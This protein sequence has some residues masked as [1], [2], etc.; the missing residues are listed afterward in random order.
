MTGYKFTRRTLNTGVLLALLP[1]AVWA[2]ART[3]ASSETLNFLVDPEPT[4]LVSITDTGVGTN[5]VTSKTTEGLFNYTNNFTLIPSLALSMTTSNDGKMITFNLRKGVKW[6]DGKPFTSA[7][8]AF[9]FDTL[10]KSH[11]RGRTT[12]ANVT[13]IQIPDESTVVLEMSAPAPYLQYALASEESPM[14][15]KHLYEGTNPATNPR[16]QAPVGTGPFI[17]KEWVRGSH[18]IFEKNPDYW[19]KSQPKV[20]RII[21]H[22][23]PD[24]AARAIA[25]ETGEV[26]IGGETPVP[27]SDVKRLS[28]LSSIGI[29]LNGYAY[30]PI[31]Q[32]I[33]FNLDN[34][35]FKELKVRQAIAHA[36]DKQFIVDNIWFGYG[37]LATGPIH[38]SQTKFY[39]PNVQKYEFDTAKAERLLDEAGFRRQ[40]DGNRFQVNL[41]PLPLTPHPL[42][43]EYLKQALAKIGIAVT[44][45]SQDFAGYMKRVYTDRQF[46][47]V[48]TAFATT[49]DPT[50]GVQRL[51]WSK[52]FRP[53]VPF[54]NGTHYQ[55]AEVDRLLEAAQI[56]IDQAKRTQEFYEFQ[57]IVAL[58]LP[59]VDLVAINYLTIFN[60]R[61]KDHT[62]TADGVK[63]SMGGTYLDG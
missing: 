63:S 14:I 9:S 32:K 57:R 56:E 37:T 40:N 47:F 21:T 23:I 58:D 22:F 26:D 13:T 34:P 28:A 39:N 18:V 5:L 17:F 61:V 62:V 15:P 49:C 25:F 52:N 30:S 7:D 20:D 45:R 50:I 53:G 42:V 46:D 51:Y 55:N 31:V 59:A 38:P 33:E 16:N 10:K 1:K 48:N 36:V 35:Y 43:A 6:H 29:E 60:K 24:A 54:T 2:Q 3:A 44:I 11:P 4:S 19:D 8:A 27:L 41:D 12:Y